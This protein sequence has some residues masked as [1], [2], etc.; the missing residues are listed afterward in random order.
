MAEKYKIKNIKE[1]TVSAMPVSEVLIK[2]FM[3]YSL[4]VIISRALPEIDGLKPSHRKLLYTMYEMGLLGGNRTK[5]ANIAARTMLLNPHGDAGNY[6]TMVRLTQNNETLLTPIVDGKGNFGKHYSRD[7]AYA[8]SRYTEA[9]LMP[10]ATEFFRSIHKD[11]VEFMDNYDGTRKEPRLLPVTFPNI[12]A[13][14]TEGIAVGMASS[15]PSFNLSELCDAA[16]M[17]IKDPKGDIMSVM[18]APDFTTGGQLICERNEMKKAYETGKGSFKIR[19]CY[20][21]DKKKRIIEVTQ[22]PYTTT[23]EAIIEGIINQVKS[24]KINEVSDVRNEIDLHGFK[25][26]IDY[27]RGTDPDLLMRKLLKLTKLEDTYS[28]NMTVLIDGQPKVLGVTGI[29]DEW[30]RWRKE[31]IRKELIYDLEKKKRELHLLEGLAKVLLDIDKAIRIIRNTENDSMVLQNLMEGFGI[32]QE[33]ASYI[34]EIKLRN[35][36]K[37]WI[38]EKT[39]NTDAVKKEI[40]VLEKQIGSDREISK[41]AIKALE[42]VK[43]KYGK[44]RR[45]TIVSA[46]EAPPAENIQMVQDYPVT[47][48]R[49]KEGYIKKVAVSSMKGSYEIKVKDDDAVVQEI[50][51]QNT[52]EILFFTDKCNVYKMYAHEMKDCR[53]SELG[54]YAANIMA[55]E[56]DEQIIYTDVLDSDKTV[57]IVFRN[58]KAAKFPMSVYETKQNRKKLLKAFSDKSPAAGICTMKDDMKMGMLSSNNRLLVFDSSM[59]PKKESRTTQGVQV[60]KLTA[61]NAEIVR[62]GFFDSFDVDKETGYG[63]RRIPSAGGVY[64]G[65]LSI[66]M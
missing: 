47:I 45:S 17:R 12:L 37:N 52:S 38:L 5:S 61:K 15:I 32:D 14:P 36:N 11:T 28:F 31:C 54:E 22:I 35:L 40:A 9:K 24:G 53:P 25:I 65:Q 16:V 3:P 62:F 10:V 60:M 56:N 66:N 21:V 42:E 43:K 49:T 58:G 51:A 30:I 34:A 18:P 23:A 19:A 44:D 57:M 46:E 63:C 41:I 20:E 33:Q 39:K 59:V 48:F 29:L 6:E 13:N 4:S 26:A 2:N 8:A 27:K 50:S 55:L 1:E 7:M 64:D